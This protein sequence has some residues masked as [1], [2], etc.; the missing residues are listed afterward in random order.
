MEQRWLRHEY[1]E[2]AQ[3]SP[4]AL[5]WLTT[6]L[7][8]LPGAQKVNAVSKVVVSTLSWSSWRAADGTAPHVKHARNTRGR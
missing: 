3:A 7:S 5:Y 8:A 2:R 4:T 1:S 6:K